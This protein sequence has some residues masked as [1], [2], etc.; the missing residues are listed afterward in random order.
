MEA[1]FKDKLKQE[2]LE[3]KERW[4]T[5]PRII[6]AIGKLLGVFPFYISK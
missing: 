5:Y 4:D 6:I 3:E 2:L 1:R